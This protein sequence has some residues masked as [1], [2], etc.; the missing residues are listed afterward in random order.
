MSTRRFSWITAV[1]AAVLAITVLSVH[2]LR[3]M[4]HFAD[5]S[6]ISLRYAQHLIEGQGLTW[7]P[8]ERVEGYSNLLWVLLIAGFGAL[9]PDHLIV[10]A[11][12]L[13]FACMSLALLAI[14]WAAVPKNLR[15]LLALGWGLM[16]LTLSGPVAAWTIGGL[17]QPLLT[18]LVLW[19]VVLARPLLQA[20]D[21][22]RVAVVGLLLG[23]ASLTRPDGIVFGAATCLGLLLASTP[24]RRGL[25][26]AIRVG[27]IALGMALA[28]MAFRKLYYDAWV[29]NTY[30]AKVAFGKERLWAG[31]VWLHY[32]LGFSL[33]VV[34]PA[35]LGVPAAIFDRARRPRVLLALSVL[36]SWMLYLVFM[37]GDAIPYRRHF[38][39]LLFLAVLVGIDGVAWLAERGRRWGLVAALPL[40]VAALVHVTWVQKGAWER[41]RALYDQSHWAGKPIGLMFRRAF[42]DADPLLAVDAAGALP[43]FSRLRTVDMLGLND[44]YLAH[45]RPKTFG[46]GVIGHELGN[47]RYLLE[48]KPDIVVFHMPAGRLLALWRGGIEMQKSPEFSREYRLVHFLTHDPF[49]QGNQSYFRV[50]R[51]IGIQ[52]S[53]G[54]IEIPGLL[55]TGR[56]GSYAE[57]DDSGRMAAIVR[58]DIPADI[59]DVSIPRGRWRVTAE[60]SE[61]LLV[62]VGEAG[63]RVW[64]AEGVGGVE[65]RQLTSRG[66][67]HLGA[68]TMSDRPAHLY[69]LV[70]TP[71]RP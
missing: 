33:G 42:A 58:S 60:S 57:L 9:S 49:E 5:D 14:V 34:L 63:A 37:G 25:W 23:L 10:I 16:A 66:G 18:A 69:R 41:E 53:Q 27:A 13:G 29:P 11:R 6:F 36:G 17:E 7:N 28:Q 32:G 59:D 21:P 31:V 64:S 51:R 62:S 68:R 55:M 67:V 46:H 40:C 54:R 4:P 50:D 52:R 2:A 35:L 61:P 19:A 44:R 24:R 15:Q 3:F 20:T 8:G 39:P 12:W 70:L 71:E 38:I 43:F 65:L 45:H 1:S 26:V 22:R 48:R 56:S 47:G 30:Y